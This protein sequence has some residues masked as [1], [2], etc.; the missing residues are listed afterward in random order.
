MAFDPLRAAGMVLGALDAEE[1]KFL[2][3]C[4]SLRDSTRVITAAHC[5]G[6]LDA[7]K[8]YVRPANVIVL[9][10][11]GEPQTHAVRV[12]EVVRHP[13]ADVAILRL[14]IQEWVIEPFW[15]AVPAHGL[16]E[17]LFAYGY[18]ENVRSDDRQPTARL[19]KG[20]VQRVYWHTSHAGYRYVAL[21]LD[22]ACPAGLSGDPCFVRLRRRW[23]SA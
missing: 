23:S 7:E 16:G 19:F 4:F 1:P 18:P 17:D 20:Y 13:D 15:N 6:D 12:R 8:L 2:G 3:S 10:K 11:P 9:N 21:E 5:I 22:F 14:G